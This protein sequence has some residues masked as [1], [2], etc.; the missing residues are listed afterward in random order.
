MKKAIAV[1]FAITTL[2]L[3]TACGNT[4]NTRC[5]SG[6]FDSDGECCDT[7]CDIDCPGGYEPGTC[8]CTCLGESDTTDSGIDD[9]FDEE[10][11][12]TPPGIPG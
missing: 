9:I 4:I 10:G 11:Q 8:H 1:L 7:V 3:L 2:F 6:M 5:D 12:I